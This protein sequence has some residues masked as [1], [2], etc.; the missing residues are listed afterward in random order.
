MDKQDL[1]IY[2]QLRLMK[3]F[4]IRLVFLL[5]LESEMIGKDRFLPFENHCL[6]LKLYLLLDNDMNIFTKSYIMSFKKLFFVYSSSCKL[7]TVKLLLDIITI[8]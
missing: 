7:I 4:Q 3:C 1:H 2:H 5:A 8:T 6:I